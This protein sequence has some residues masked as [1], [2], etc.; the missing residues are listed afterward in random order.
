MP[1]R[2]RFLWIAGIGAV[3]LAAVGGGVAVAL[4]GGS[5]H[6]DGQTGPTAST[7]APVPKGPA[8]T[9]SHALDGH[10]NN[11]DN[12]GGLGVLGDVL[13][14]W[15]SSTAQAFDLATGAPRWTGSPDL[16]AGY[17]GF[18][19]IG[20]NDSLLIGATLN[21]D[22]DSSLVFA[23]GS[24]GKQQFSH[25]VGRNANGTRFSQVFD[26]DGTVALLGTTNEIVAINVSSGSQLWRRALTAYDVA[27]AVIGGQ[28]CYLQDYT[29]TFCLD[30]TSG[31]QLWATPN[32][33][34]NSSSIASAADALAIAGDQLGDHL[35]VLDEATGTR[36]PTAIQS[37]TGIN[38]VCVSDDLFIVGEETNESASGEDTYRIWGINP[39]DGSKVWTTLITLPVVTGMT[40]SA[41][42]VIVP[43][44]TPVSMKPAGFLVLDGK[45]GAIAWAESGGGADDWVACATQEAVYAASSTTVYAYPRHP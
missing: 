41:G 22:T 1:N 23:I 33:A 2:R 42:L 38:Q 10:F 7:G 36:R 31:N 21:D 8:P 29:A 40:T 15:D 34:S 25:D 45:T 18:S 43:T 35:V 13:I 24:D 9:W 20:L 32:T 16:P 28:R 5:K 39:R 3:G 4:T 6:P 37:S 19:W 27:S 11:S 44:Q 17:S 14:R 12:S 30:M 26:F